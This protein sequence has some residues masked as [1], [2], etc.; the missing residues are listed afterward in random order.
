MTTNIHE[1]VNN[2]FEGR[3]TANEEKILRRF[4]A[5]DNIPE[6]L[7]ELAPIFAFLEDEAQALSVLD[8]IKREEKKSTAPPKTKRL[9]VVM[10][11]I[12]ALAASFFIGIVLL[13]RPVN[14]FSGNY[15][16]VD[17][18]RITNPEM[19]RQYAEKSFDRVKT[20]EN[21]LEEQLNFM[22]E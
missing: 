19:V 5:Q 8:E 18:K 11:T 22:F 12:A 17:G 21:I 14:R 4:F 16:W 7:R 13:Y 3:T 2:Y 20:E 10:W 1:L 9:R 15:A 6:D